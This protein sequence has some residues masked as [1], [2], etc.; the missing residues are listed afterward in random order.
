[1][2][3][4]ETTVTESAVETTVDPVEELG[5]RI[6]TEGLGA[7]HLATA[8]LGVELG[9]FAAIDA[10]PGITCAELAETTG[11]DARYTQEWVQAEYI[12]GLL[13]SDAAD[14]TTGGLTLADGVREVLVDEVHPGYL[15]GLARALA[16]VGSALPALPAAYRSGA[17]V[18]AEAYGPEVV[19][20]QA[21]LNRPAFVHELAATW[22]P[23]MPDVHTRLSDATE[24]ARVA[25]VGCGAGWSAIELA[26]AFPHVRID[27]YDVDAP[28]IETATRNATAHGVADRVSFH[29]LDATAGSYGDGGYD[30]I[31]FFE[32]LH[33]IARPADALTAARRSIAADGTVIVMDERTA[34]EPQVGDMI[35]TFFASASALWCLPQSRN[36]PDCDAPGAVMRPAAFEAF[37]RRA[38]WAGYEVVPIEHP[39]FRFY[40]LVR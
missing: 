31:F 14:F 3:L 8:Y 40:R 19:V 15:G 4:T 11:V 24:P 38:G 13:H 32:C 28:A 6:F 26:K 18:P 33:D 1:M 34:D 5:G 37:A 27:G 30:A 29:V 20:A 7:M 17:G 10:K 2:T 12:A 36:T 39:V 9:L 23:A 16:A 22:L 35:E 25:D 21:Q